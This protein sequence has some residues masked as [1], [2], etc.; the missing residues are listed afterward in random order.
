M[1]LEFIFIIKY[2]KQSSCPRTTT[3]RMAVA[4][5]PALM[6]MT[7]SW[8]CQSTR[9]VQAEILA[10]CSLM[11]LKSSLWF[12]AS[13]Q[14][15]GMNLSCTVPVLE[16]L[17]SPWLSKHWRDKVPLQST[18]NKYSKYT[19]SWL[20]ISYAIWNRILTIIIGKNTRDKNLWDLLSLM[21]RKVPRRREAWLKPWTALKKSED[22]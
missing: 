7:T 10:I 8:D 4:T 17:N 9:L 5:T 12:N 21:L 13:L 18:S 14:G 22:G 19:G 6:R 20:K 11:T 2:I 1:Q 3:L 16:P 15:Q